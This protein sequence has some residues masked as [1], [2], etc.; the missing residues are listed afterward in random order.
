[1]VWDD[2]A[3]VSQPQPVG[4]QYYFHYYLYN[5]FCS[6]WPYLEKNAVSLSFKKVLG[7][8]CF[9]IFSSLNLCIL[10]KSPSLLF[11]CTV[12]SPSWLVS[13]SL[14]LSTYNV[15]YYVCDFTWFLYFSV[16]ALCY[17]TNLTTTNKLPICTW[18][19]KS[20]WKYELLTIC[21]LLRQ[22]VSSLSGSSNEGA[23]RAR[24]RRKDE[25]SEWS[26]IPFCLRFFVCLHTC[27]IIFLNMKYTFLAHGQ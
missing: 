15:E 3:Y 9:N 8:T 5:Y 16:V 17:N 21:H 7:K 1:M 19:L 4:S 26:F 24:K 10:L 18:T 13:L 25:I 20:G 27:F 11:S 22:K 12:I 6:I 2:D 23:Q 14:S